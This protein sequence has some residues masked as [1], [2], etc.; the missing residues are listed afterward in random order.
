MT[1]LTAPAT[2][3]RMPRMTAI[4]AYW[5]EHATE[6]FPDVK[7]TAVG[8]GEPFCFRCGWLAP[9]PTND[10]PV[11]KNA[12]TFHMWNR[13]GGW[14]ERAHLHDRAAGGSDTPDNIV[15]LCHP[16]HYA[17]P[18]FTDSRDEAIA[19]VM[20]APAKACD[21]LWQFATD[22]QWGGEKY[23]PYPGWPTVHGFRLHLDEFVRDARRNGAVVPIDNLTTST[24]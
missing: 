15:P 11:A 13:I 19:W 7:G 10:P 4:A 23:T 17:M 1:T 6:V 2:A 16:C 22:A 18:Q 12:H 8:W 21:R 20:P 24:P 3:R 9:I 14:L 5:Y